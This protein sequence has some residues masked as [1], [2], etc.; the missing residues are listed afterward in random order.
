ML[1]VFNPTGN[2]DKN[3]RQMFYGNSTGII[4]LNNVKYNWAIQLWRQ[5]RENFW[6]AEKIDISLDITDYKNLTSSEVRAFDGILSYLVFLD[7]VQV[8]NIPHIVRPCSAPELSLCFA[9]QLT[10]EGLHGQSYQYIIETVIPIE[11]REFI[12]SYWKNDPV[13][14]D[15]CELIGNYYQN[16][17]DKPTNENHLI[18]L[19]A[20][21][22]L[23]GLYFYVGFA[24][25]YN[26]ASRS[27]MCGSADIF[28]MINRD[29]LSHVRLYQNIILNQLERLDKEEKKFIESVAI[30]MFKTAVDQEIRW[31]THIIGNDI[32]GMP[33]QAIEDY[34]KY[35]ANIRLKAV[36]LPII[37]EG[38]KNSFKHL[39]K[40][41]DTSKEAT[42][43][44]NFFDSTVTSYQMATAV[45]GWNDI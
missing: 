32:L 27:V 38:A 21:Y 10:Q 14:F 42:T 7:S 3:S 13:L 36:G 22:I 40:I 4:N 35:L 33:P 2:D 25:F 6:V 34:V 17:I 24:F 18:A 9:E 12:Y 28:K 26:L 41:A 45:D 16:Y 20:D 5:M 15:R 23:E 11:K 29:E 44:T 8:Q 1:K 43:K 30:E 31:S 39:E 19:I 37:Y